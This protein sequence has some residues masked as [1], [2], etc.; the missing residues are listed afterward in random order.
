[1]GSG[2]FTK[3]EEC[4]LTAQTLISAHSGVASR[5]WPLLLAEVLPHCYN[6]LLD[7]TDVWRFEQRRSIQRRLKNQVLRALAALHFFKPPV[8]YRSKLQAVLDA[9]SFDRTMDL[10]EDDASRELLVKLMAYRILGPR[11]Y[12]LPTNNPDY[13][14]KQRSVD[15]FIETRQALRHG[16]HFES[17]T[18]FNCNGVR[19][20][21]DALHILNTFIVEQYRLRRVEIGVRAGDVV[22]DGGACWGDTSLY[23]A[24][25]ARH[26]FAWECMTANLPLL[27]RNIGLNPQLASKITVVDRAMWS[28][29][30][31]ELCFEYAGSG[32][33]MRLESEEDLQD[34]ATDTIDN[35]VCE[36]DVAPVD[37]IKMDIEGAEFNALRGAETTIRRFRPRLAICVY[38][39]LA[40]FNRIPQWIR[41][42]D[43]GYRLYLD[44]FTIHEEESILFAEAR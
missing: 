5:F 29:P 22:I 2:S 35:Y 40:D 34:V 36:H 23:F 14:Q 7:N 19:L 15:E 13:W 26:V 21:A 25:A 4:F 33:H 41:D 12:R 16:P 42:L 17:L 30:H 38:H 43:L 1:M 10:F 18:L 27:H 24:R 8:N 11:H 32:S 31:E 28:E 9:G 20:I 37:F 44:H 39:S 3:F 6:L